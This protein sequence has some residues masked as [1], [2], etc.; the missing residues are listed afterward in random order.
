MSVVKVINMPGPW[1]TGIIFVA[2]EPITMSGCLFY[3]YLILPPAHFIIDEGE[4]H[5]H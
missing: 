1:I 4:H 3:D 5:P 2:D